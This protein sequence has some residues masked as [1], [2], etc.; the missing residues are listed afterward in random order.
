MRNAFG[1]GGPRPAPARMEPTPI[2]SSDPEHGHHDEYTDD[3][4]YSG[5]EYTEST[6]TGVTQSHTATSVGLPPP[7]PARALPPA[8]GGRK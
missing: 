8:K 7:Q 5:S 2:G 3:D 1:G 4:D 6:F